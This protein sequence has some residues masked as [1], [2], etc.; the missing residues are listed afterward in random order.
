MS[1][2][3]PAFMEPKEQARQPINPAT[4]TAIA[5]G[6][7]PPEISGSL[8]DGILM[9]MLTMIYGSTPCPPAIGP[10]SAETT[11]KIMLAYTARKE[12]LPQPTSPVPDSD[13]ARG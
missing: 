7:T 9:A 4:G 11:P 6:K 13:K 1:P 3:S 10:G 2:I 5:V 8:A 12:L